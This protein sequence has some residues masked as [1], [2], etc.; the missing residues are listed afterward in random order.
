M[1][2]GTD[3]NQV[4]A[5]SSLAVARGDYDG[6]GDLDLAMGNW[7]QVKRLYRNDSGVLTRNASSVAHLPPPG[8]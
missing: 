8:P 5:N 7:G 6:D 4:E 3:V 1:I 2:R